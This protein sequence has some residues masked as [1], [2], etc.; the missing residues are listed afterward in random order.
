MN[1]RQEAAI[2]TPLRDVAT[3]NM[4]PI[5]WTAELIGR[6]TGHT[7]RC[8]KRIGLP[9][10]VWRR[11][12]RADSLEDVLRRAILA[13]TAR[14]GIALSGEEIREL[15][16]KIVELLRNVFSGEIGVGAI[17]S[18]AELVRSGSVFSDFLVPMIRE[19]GGL[20]ESKREMLRRIL[21]DNLQLRQASLEAERQ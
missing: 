4:D 7:V 20:S 16:G 19:S 14:T 9:R 10:I 15:I 6:G 12:R 8:L 13:E 5:C 17:P 18:V 3:K 1:A 2:Q 11:P 21:E